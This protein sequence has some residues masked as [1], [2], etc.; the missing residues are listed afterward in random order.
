MCSNSRHEIAFVDI[1]IVEISKKIYLKPRPTKFG[2]ISTAMDSND[3]STETLLEQEFEGSGAMVQARSLRG[4]ERLCWLFAIIGLCSIFTLWITGNSDFELAPKLR[5]EPMRKPC[6]KNP[7]E[8]IKLGCEW[9]VLSFCWLPEQ[10]LDRELTEEFRKAGPWTY[11]GDMNKTFVV[12]EVDFGMHKKTV[13]LTNELHR[14]HCAFTWLK[15]HK[16]MASGKRIHDQLSLGHTKHCSKVL[17]YKGDLQNI[18]NYAIIQYPDCGYFSE[19]FPG[20]GRPKKPT[21]IAKS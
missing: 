19:Q 17:Q 21:L 15:L 9:D 14:A 10:C 13:W 11:Y 6:G 5:A 16:A 1:K 20:S 3:G 4:R 2:R 7:E 18:E 8:A 12:S